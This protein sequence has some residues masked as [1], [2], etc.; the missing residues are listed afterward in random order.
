MIFLPKRRKE[1]RCHVTIIT[2]R[3]HILTKRENPNK[4]TPEK[5]PSIRP[6]ENLVRKRKY[7]DSPAAIM[8][9]QGGRR[10]THVRESQV[11]PCIILTGIPFADY[12]L[13]EMIIGVIKISSLVRITVPPLFTVILSNLHF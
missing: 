3:P 12:I 5:P 10:T 9:G 7:Q 2:V 6:Q 1:F 13:Y 8:V 4:E 11:F